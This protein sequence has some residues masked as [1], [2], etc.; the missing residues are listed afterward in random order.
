MISNDAIPLLSRCGSSSSD[1][2]KKPEATPLSGA[3]ATAAPVA[4]ASEVGHQALSAP[5]GA[6]S[7]PRVR[8]MPHA[9]QNKVPHLAPGNFATYLPGYEPGTD[10]RRTSPVLQIEALTIEAEEQNP[11]FSFWDKVGKSHHLRKELKTTA[12]GLGL[13]IELGVKLTHENAQDLLLVLD[14]FKGCGISLDGINVRRTP[15]GDR[16]VRDR[17]SADRHV[18]PCFIEGLLYVSKDISDKDFREG[19]TRLL[20]HKHNIKNSI[21][22]MVMQPAS[23]AVQAWITDLAGGRPNRGIDDVCAIIAARCIETGKPIIE[24]F[25]ADTLGIYKALGGVDL[26][27]NMGAPTRPSAT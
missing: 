6:A 15:A 3:T 27:P 4:R 7:A 21:D 13:K 12:S 17:A 23:R 2:G 20:L 24:V 26:F 22:T 1:E 5:A 16:L 10:G 11:G 19:L 9:Q 8:P 25:D 18:Y 14:Q